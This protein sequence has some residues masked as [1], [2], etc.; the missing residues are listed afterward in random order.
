MSVSTVNSPYVVA[1]T[2][3]F[4][5][6]V[7]ARHHLASLRLTAGTIRAARQ[8]RRQERH[9]AWVRTFYSWCEAFRGLGFM[10]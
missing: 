10:F 3:V 9:E 8:R 6:Y 5:R 2:F 7:T 1:K 4:R